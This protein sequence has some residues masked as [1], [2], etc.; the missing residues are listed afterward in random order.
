LEKKAW[1]ADVYGITGVFLISLFYRPKRPAANPEAPIGTPK[2]L[3]LHE[4]REHKL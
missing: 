4:A 1:R 3:L 2:K